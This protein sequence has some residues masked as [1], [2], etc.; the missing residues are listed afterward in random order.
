M[1]F[2]LFVLAMGIVAAAGN[3]LENIIYATAIINLPFYA[4]MARTEVAVRRN[5]GYVQAARL[6][7]NADWRILAFQIFPNAPRRCPWWSL[8]RAGSAPGCRSPG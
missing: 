7:G 3:T 4:R 8:G 2:P 5:A 6:S 1:A